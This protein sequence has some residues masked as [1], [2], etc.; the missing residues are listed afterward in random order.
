VTATRK[1]LRNTNKGVIQN[2]SSNWL[3][4]I[5]RQAQYSSN[6]VKKELL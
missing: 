3:L 6:G 4:V 1:A 2:K 5:L